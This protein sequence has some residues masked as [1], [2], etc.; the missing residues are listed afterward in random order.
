MMSAVPKS[1][2]LVRRWGEM[3]KFSH[4]V[5]ALPF[6]VMAAFLASRAAAQARGS[7]SYSPSVI[8]LLLVIGC[9]VTARS[10]AMT[11]NRIVDATIDARNA[12]TAGRAIPAG[13]ISRRQAYIFLFVAALLFV[14]CCGGFWFLKNNMVP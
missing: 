10:V 6:A 3:I 11:F 14:L 8:Q 2:T 9:M 12:R 5:F 4:S 1:A 13:Q 7:D